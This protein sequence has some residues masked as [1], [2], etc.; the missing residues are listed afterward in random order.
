MTSSR[1]KITV[2][3]HHCQFKNSLGKDVADKSLHLAY[4]KFILCPNIEIWFLDIQ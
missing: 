2:G 4:Q 3:V 1:E